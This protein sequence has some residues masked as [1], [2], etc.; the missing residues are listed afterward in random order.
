MGVKRVARVERSGVERVATIE[1][2]E[3]ECVWCGGLPYRFSFVHF[4]FGT[5]L[6]LRRDV[7]WDALCGNGEDLDIEDLCNIPLLGYCLVT[8]PFRPGRLFGSMT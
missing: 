2:S 6:Q 7:L 8:F 5:R 4:C 3:V 1:W